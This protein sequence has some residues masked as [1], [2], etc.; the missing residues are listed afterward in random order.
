MSELTTE[1]IL[2]QLPPPQL[3]FLAELADELRPEPDDEPPAPTYL[4]A[5][6]RGTPFELLHA[7]KRAHRAIKGPPKGHE[8]EWYRELGNEL[9]KAE[10]EAGDRLAAVLTVDEM[11]NYLNAAKKNKRDYLMLRLF[12]ASGMRLEEVDNLLVGD[13]H[14]DTCKIFVRFG[15][16]DK[17]R[18]VLVDQETCDLLAEW[19]YSMK[20]SDQV[21]DLGERQIARRVKHWGQKLGFVERFDAIGRRFSSRSLR[22]TMATHLYEGGADLMMI[23]E[24]LGHIHLSTTEIY[25]HIGVG[26]MADRYRAAHPLCRDQR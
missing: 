21:F 5:Q 9:T 14:F 18:Y 22:H 12:Y 15:K 3:E 10:I 19:C 20:E 13:I 7:A 17:D 23:K 8:L 11:R 16:G 2:A 25:V 6:R 26:M 24:L 1:E 4:S